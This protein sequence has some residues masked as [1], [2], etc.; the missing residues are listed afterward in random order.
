[1][2]SDSDAIQEAYG[3][4]SL[5]KDLV[6]TAARQLLSV[7]SMANRHE[8]RACLRAEAEAYRVWKALVSGE[9]VADL[10]GTEEF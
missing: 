2:I 5:T 6:V 8:L 10:R 3:Q 4:W 9:L 7:N 1:M